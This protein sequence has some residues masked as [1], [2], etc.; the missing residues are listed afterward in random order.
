MYI[1]KNA[2]QNIQKMKG[3]S[4][5]IFT[6]VL[7]I[8][9]AACVALGIQGSADKAREV[10]FETMEIHAQIGV[11]R[12][13][14][15][16][17][18]FD[19][20]NM[21]EM[22]GRMTQELS[23]E[24]A[25]TYSEAAEVSNF[26][27]TSTGSVNAASL[28]AYET[29]SGG[30]MGGMMDRGGMTGGEGGMASGTYQ[31]TGYS[32]LDAMELFTEGTLTV[33]DGTVFDVESGS[34][35]VLIS[36]E[37]AFLNELS[38][39]DSVTLESA[40]DETVFTTV[41]IV[42]LFSCVSTD[43]YANQIYLS[44]AAFDE[45]ATDLQTVN[46]EGESTFFSQTSPTYVFASVEDYESFQTTAVSMGLDDETYL[47]SSPDIT[48]F[49]ESLVPLESMAS[50]VLTFLIVVLLIGAAVL[51]LFNLFIIR[52][53]K[54]EIGVLAAM[55]MTKAKVALQ[56]VSE[57]L[58][59]CF[60]AILCSILIGTIIATPV[61]ESLLA[62][63][64][65]SLEAESTVMQGNF[66]MRGDSGGGMMAG[67]M[68]GMNNLPGAN[69]DYL[70]SIQVGIDAVALVQLLLIGLGLSLVTSFVSVI[71]I[72]RYEPLKILSER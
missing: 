45:V 49:E 38:V 2:L 16:S 6:I 53:R 29:S 35:D 3:R 11:D 65:A 50:F 37:L 36:E 30:M 26:Y 13:S 42:G 22:M 72:L 47:I 21:D 44:Q 14:M 28:T 24:E 70:S 1:F 12:A 7:V 61:G 41:T 57:N 15:M 25:I 5:L 40:Q 69:V 23:L 60:V 19:P 56:F 46:E 17:G 58:I 59:V 54:Y 4:V 63:Q 32:A 10:A 31:L 67:G 68:P 20:E 52:E 66:G 18:G 8:A 9:T 64:I 51:A 39:G 48:A 55:G 27:Y 71:T 43:S 34:T 62:G 33:S